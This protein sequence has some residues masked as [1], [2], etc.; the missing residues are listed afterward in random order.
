MTDSDQNA[1]RRKTKRFCATKGAF[2][3]VK[4]DYSLMGPI[5]DISMGGVSFRYL[6]SKDKVENVSVISLL[7]VNKYIFE[8]IQVETVSDFKEETPFAS[9][10][11]RLRRQ[12]LKFKN[13]LPHQ[14]SQLE[15]FIQNC[16]VQ[17]A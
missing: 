15:D 10:C 12:G 13:L 5:V 17:D 4:P 14:I 3:V 16:T 9:G 11:T 1:E 7:Y 2:A 6:D 8:N